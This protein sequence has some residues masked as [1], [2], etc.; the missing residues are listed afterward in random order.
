MGFES[1]SV[2]RTVGTVCLVVPVAMVILGQTALKNSLQGVAF[3]TYWLVCVIF[4][5]V[6]ILVALVDL[7][8]VRRQ[9][10]EETRAL[11]EKT[12]ADIEG[13]RGEKPTSPDETA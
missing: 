9:T 7:R 12:L 6:A 8:S 1:N 3:L 10:Q 2:R 4:T 13:Q 5:F 11:F